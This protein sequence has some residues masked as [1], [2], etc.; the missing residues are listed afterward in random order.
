MLVVCELLMLLVG[1]EVSVDV[2][3]VVRVEVWVEVLLVVPVE[4]REDV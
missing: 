2:L 1:D 4:L 3:V